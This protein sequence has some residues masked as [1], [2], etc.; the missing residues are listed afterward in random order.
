MRIMYLLAAHL[1]PCRSSLYIN[2]MSGLLRS[3]FYITSFLWGGRRRE[4]F[5]SSSLC[6]WSQKPWQSR[7]KM[8]LLQGFFSRTPRIRRIVKICDAVD[9]F[10]RKPFWFFLNIFSILGSMRLRSRAW[11]ILAAMDV[12][13]I[14]R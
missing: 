9:R 1:L 10:L 11:Y 14:H 6:V 2:P 7:R 3:C 13:V 12:R 8:V 4:V 5:A